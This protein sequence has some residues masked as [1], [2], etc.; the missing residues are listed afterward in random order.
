V[1]APTEAHAEDE[2]H[3]TPL[4]TLIAAPAGFGVGWN[5]QASPFRL[6]ARLTPV[7]DAST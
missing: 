7:P 3:D 5:V 4:R 6:S 2:E 1:Y